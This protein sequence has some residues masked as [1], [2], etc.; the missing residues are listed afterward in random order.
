MELLTQPRHTRRDPARTIAAIQTSVIVPCHNAGENLRHQ[1]EALRRQNMRER[2]E[3]IVVD[4]RSTDESA[5]IAR[6]FLG[7]LPRLRLVAAHGRSGPSYA[8]N[9]GALIADGET[10]LFC[11]ADDVVAD[12]WVATMTRAVRQHGFVACR[13]DHEAL[14]P[15][16][17]RESRGRTQ[18]RDLLKSSFLEMASGGTLG[19]R[20]E[21]FFGAGGFDEAMRTVQ[22]LEFCWRVQLCG[23]PLHFLPDTVVHYRHRH[24][25][26]AAFWQEHRF[27]VDY[28]KL[29][30]RYRKLGHE[31]PTKTWRGFAWRCARI[32]AQLPRRLGSRDAR[33][34][35]ATE[36]GHSLGILR[37]AFARVPC[38]QRLLT[39]QAS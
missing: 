15:S 30:R 14:N 29:V 38:E 23:T 13:L 27:G 5:A 39:P 33:A 19:I 28:M 24:D 22:D 12:D 4:N 17:S 16:W 9:R 34:G 31:I 7:R 1:L 6:S 21:V 32:L 20:R 35:W 2:W 25:I 3:V 26:R 10:L 8:R 36:F 18:E 11:D 37:G